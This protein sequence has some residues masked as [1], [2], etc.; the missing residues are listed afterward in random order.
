MF[1][2]II[3][4]FFL[5]LSFVSVTKFEIFISDKATAPYDGTENNPFSS[6]YSALAITDTKYRATASPLD[7][8]FFRIAP[9]SAFSQYYIKDEDI[10]EGQLFKDF[11]G[12]VN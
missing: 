5:R 1:P 11:H 7:Q 2:F 8:F 12:N 3:S 6:I 10:S 4:F 9:S